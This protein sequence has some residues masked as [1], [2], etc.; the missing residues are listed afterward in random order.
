MVGAAAVRRET[1]Y[2]AVMDWAMH[3]PRARLAAWAAGGAVDAV[4]VTLVLPNWWLVALPLVCIASIGAWG[5]A[6]QRLE[7]LRMAPAPA[8]V[9]RFALEGV[10]AATVAV[11]T[12]AAIVA[13]YAALL[14]LLGPRWG[15]TG[16]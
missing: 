11:G 12:L 14:I 1:V 3:A 16:G 10:K 4:G 2:D 6:A 15:P 8:R 5:L 9:Q 7:R 13:L